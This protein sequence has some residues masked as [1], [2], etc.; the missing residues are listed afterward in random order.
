VAGLFGKKGQFQPSW[1]WSLAKP[2]LD[3]VVF[4][5]NTLHC[6][7]AVSRKLIFLKI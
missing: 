5:R 4:P 6:G 2:Y 3:P 7:L 1:N